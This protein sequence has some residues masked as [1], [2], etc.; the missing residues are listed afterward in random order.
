MCNK[1]L[2]TLNIINIAVNVRRRLSF[3]LV[4][5]GLS[6]GL[7]IQIFSFIKVLESKLIL[8]SMQ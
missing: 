6:K 3:A 8:I 5:R 1:L 2:I 7:P 4:S